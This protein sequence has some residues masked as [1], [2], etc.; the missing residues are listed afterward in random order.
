M[1]K[2]NISVYKLNE[3]SKDVQDRVIE[4]YQD[5][6]AGFLYAN[7]ENVMNRELNNYTNNLDFRLDYSLNYCQGDGVSFDGTVKDK[8]ELLTL[9]L[10]VYND[11]VPNNIV[12]LIKHE[13]ISSVKFVRSTSYYVHKYTVT[14]T[15]IDNNIGDGY[16][17]IRRAIAAFEKAINE[18]YLQ[19]CD[20]LE[21]IGYNTIENLYSEDTIKSYIE[22]NE[23]E[24]FIDGRD[25]L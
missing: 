4:R 23:F 19:T 15:I 16:C 20:N 2:V 5:E 6:L 25:F 7:L 12:K 22:S 17:H 11:R 10:L 8:D 18:W 3:L 9:A 14:P 21:K 1:R 24:F 13:I